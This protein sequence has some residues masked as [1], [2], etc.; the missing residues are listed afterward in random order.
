MK[1]VLNEMNIEPQTKED[2]KHIDL[3]IREIIGK[4]N[5]DKCNEVWGEVKEWLND[6]QKKQKLTNKLKDNL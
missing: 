6:P 1:N 4:K 5:E 2:R 3:T